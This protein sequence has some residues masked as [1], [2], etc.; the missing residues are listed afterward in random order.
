MIDISCSKLIEYLTPNK[1]VKHDTTVSGVEDGEMN[2][3]GG[4]FLTVVPAVGVIITPAAEAGIGI[5]FH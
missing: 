1:R 4:K 5:L 2:G 3:D